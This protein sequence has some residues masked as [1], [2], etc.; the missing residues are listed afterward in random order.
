MHDLLYKLPPGTEPI[1]HMT[2]EHI[3]HTNAKYKGRQIVKNNTSSCSIVGARGKMTWLLG[4]PPGLA[5]G[6]A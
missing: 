4:K 2:N 6:T 1:Q 3:Y 5:H